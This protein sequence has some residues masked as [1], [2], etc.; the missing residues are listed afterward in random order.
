MRP[1][2]LELLP[3]RTRAVRETG[4]KRLEPFLNSERPIRA[5]TDAGRHICLSRRRYL[6]P[7]PHNSPGV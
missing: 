5:E 6:D 7:F 1:V 2:V 4:R 3:A